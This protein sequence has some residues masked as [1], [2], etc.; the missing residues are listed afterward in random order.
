MQE[1]GDTRFGKKGRSALRCR[2]HPQ[3][4]SLG[5]VSSPPSWE[6]GSCKGDGEVGRVVD[7]GRGLMRTDALGKACVHLTLVWTLPN[8]IPE[9]QTQQFR[10]LQIL[11]G[12][13]FFFLP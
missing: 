2:E 3:E 11:R 12:S 7:K 6:E 9:R 1:L 13:I 5:G 4:G 10:L 8:W